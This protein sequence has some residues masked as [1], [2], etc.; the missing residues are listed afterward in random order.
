MLDILDAGE[1]AA[2]AGARRGRPPGGRPPKR[3]GGGRKRAPRGLAPR[4]VE[5]GLRDHPGSTVQEILGLAATDAE[6]LIRL[7]SIRTELRNG[8]K[9]G[10]Y[11]L[12]DGRWS[13]AASA[14]AATNEDGSSAVP[15][16]VEPERDDAA[17]APTG[18]ATGASTSDP[19]SGLPGS[20]R[21]LGA[22]LLDRI[23]D[24]DEKIDGLGRELRARACQGEEAARLMT[25]PGIG[26]IT[27]MAVQAFAPPMES[28][29]RGRD[30][31][32]W[33]GLV[34]RQHTTGGKP[35]LGR[36]PGG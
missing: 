5:Q 11:E 36:I 25:I 31:A 12:R 9:Q 18:D 1:R 7:S 30:F 17:G 26:P 8:R 2:P 29:R 19:G 10:R 14:S 6:R 13:L 4:F 22:L 34:P 28:F 15:P 27:A 32:G 35:R 33:L 20:V 23:E 24:L 21:E 3:R 16:K